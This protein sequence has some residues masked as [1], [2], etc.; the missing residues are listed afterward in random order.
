MGLREGSRMNVAGQASIALDH[1]SILWSTSTNSHNCICA[2]ARRILDEWFQLR[3][4]CYSHA[5]LTEA[6][7]FVL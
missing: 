4:E 5:L 1:Q 6:H 2:A 3:L 7:M